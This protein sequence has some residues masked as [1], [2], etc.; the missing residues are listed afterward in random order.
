M[1]TEEY[2]EQVKEFSIGFLEGILEGAKRYYV[3][4]INDNIVPEEEP[5]KKIYEIGKNI[6]EGGNWAEEIKKG[7]IS[8][9]NEID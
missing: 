1:G 3:K 9:L 4:C 8:A 2:R 5:K 7:L 6:S